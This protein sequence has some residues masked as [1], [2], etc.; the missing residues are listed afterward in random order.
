MTIQVG[1]FG[2]GKAVTYP[3]WGGRG[4]FFQQEPSSIRI[5]G[6]KLSIE[7]WADGIDS[8][9]SSIV[10]STPMAENPGIVNGAQIDFQFARHQLAGLMDAARGGE[11]YIPIISDTDAAIGGIYT[12]ESVNTIA[13]PVS[14]GDPTMGHAGSFRYQVI[15]D[16]VPAYKRP[17]IESR[18]F[19]ALRP[20]DHG[21]VSDKTWWALPYDARWGTANSQAA[22]LG[23]TLVHNTVCETSPLVNQGIDVYYEDVATGLEDGAVLYNIP[24]EVWYEGACEIRIMNHPLSGV[25]APYGYGAYKI[26]NGLVMLEWSSRAGGGIVGD[27]SVYGS[28]GW[29]PIFTLSVGDEVNG[30]ESAGGFLVAV[31]PI[32]NTVVECILRFT[33]SMGDGFT[34]GI[35]NRMY[36]VDVRVRRGARHM[37]FVITAN[38]DARWLLNVSNSA[39]LFGS[40]LMTDIGYGIYAAADNAEGNRAAIFCAQA[41][42]STNLAAGYI[43]L[44]VASKIGNFALVAEM[45]GAAAVASD[46]LTVIRDSWLWAASERMR[47][48]RT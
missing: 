43:S 20:N 41:N 13:D 35:Q 17:L 18:F 47:V 46:A 22:T 27:F 24:F 45:G 32:K 1:R 6:D 40:P 15:A 25:Q 29:E 39:P 21:L 11:K 16:R 30:F 23:Q 42:T 12:I 28:T 37:D 48:L 3:Q 36:N 4:S 2:F 9:P 19:G 38:F 31:T 8:D 14:Y 33:Y 44:D 34:A 26:T 10:Q 5:D 7:G